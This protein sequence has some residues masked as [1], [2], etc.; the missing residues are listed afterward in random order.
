MYGKQVS[1][2]GF[3]KDMKMGQE[4]LLYLLLAQFEDLRDTEPPAEQQGLLR[5]AVAWVRSLLRLLWLILVFTPA[6]ITAPVAF[7]YGIHRKRWLVMFRC[8]YP[9]VGAGPWECGWSRWLDE[10]GYPAWSVWRAGELGRP[11]ISRAFLG[12]S[13]A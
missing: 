1:S 8:V 6:A 12:G 3:E 2:L 5:R 11:G 4:N 7:G 10:A 13:D 9:S